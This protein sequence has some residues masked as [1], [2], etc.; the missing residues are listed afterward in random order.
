M[1]HLQPGVHLEEEEPRRVAGA[2]E[3]ELDGAGVDVA[4]RA[5]GRHG[6]VA[7]ALAQRRASA[8]DDGLS[9]IDLLV[10]PLNRALALE[11]VDDVAVRCRRTPGSRRGAAARPAARRT[12]VPSP[13]AACASRRA[14]LDGFTSLTSASRTV[15]MPMPPPPADGLISAGTPIAS[16]GGDEGCVGLIVRRLAGHDRHAGLL[17][18]LPG[19]NLRAHALDAPPAADRRRSARR[20]RTPARSSRAPR[21][22][23][24]RDARRRRRPAAP[25]RA[26]ASTL[27]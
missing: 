27:R 10:P 8:P 9:S 1:L 19:A 12:S 24:I 6:R 5:G 25:R 13:N 22:S 7:H 16:H 26:T 20:R 23:R 3:Q 14:A 15:F 11:Q 2:L 18:Q 17:H 21:E 4:G